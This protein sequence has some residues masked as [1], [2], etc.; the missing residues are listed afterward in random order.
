MS[1]RRAAEPRRTGRAEHE[2]RALALARVAARAACR[3][4]VEFE[5]GVRARRRHGVRRRSSST[6]TAG[7]SGSAAAAS[8]REGGAARGASGTARLPRRRLRLPERS[9]HEGTFIDLR[10]VLPEPAA[11][12]RA[13]R[14]RSGPS[15][16]AGCAALVYDLSVHS[17]FFDEQDRIIDGRA[18]TT[19]RTPRARSLLARPRGGASSPSSTRRTRELDE[20]VRGFTQE[21]HERHGFY[22]RRMVWP[23]PQV[24]RFL[25]RTNLK[26]RGYAGDAEMM[27]LMLRE[28]VRRAATSSTSSCTSTPS[29]RR[30][31][32]RCARA[33]SSCRACCATCWR[34]SR[35]SARTGSASSRSPSGP[36]CELARDRRRARRTRSASTCTLLD[37][38]PFALDLARETIAPPRGRARRPPR[39]PLRRRTRSAPCSATRDLGRSGSAAS[40]SSTRWGSSTT[41]RR[42]SRARC[43]RGVCELVRA[44]RHAPRRELPRRAR[45]TPRPH[46]RTGCDWSLCY[47][48]EEGFRALAEGLEDVATSGIEFDHTG[49]QMFLRLE[50]AR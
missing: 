19:W 30:A 8:R 46:G 43:S 10:G 24:G 1:S 3:S 28:R 7:R 5:G 49:C 25:R 16:S 26:P 21:E 33:A 37:Q 34:A 13:A 15:S 38:D 22:L 4:R 45:R 42:R 44:G 2:G 6:S 14:A 36:A 31:R 48:T 27:R 35:T 20:L 39:G 18:A 11:R 32:R 17:R 47:R 23:Y 9:S 29:R 40:T 41:S 12:H 50:K